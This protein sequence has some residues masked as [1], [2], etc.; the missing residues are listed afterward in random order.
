MWIWH[1]SKGEMR[2]V[3]GTLFSSGYSGHGVGKNE[4]SAQQVPNTGPIPV[5][6]YQIGLPFDDPHKG[7]C[8][9]SLTPHPANL[10][11]GRSGFLIHGDNATHDAS[12]GCIILPPWA[13]Q[14][15]ARSGDKLLVV[16]P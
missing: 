6:A 4:P 15:L 9:M 12:E 14:S 3:D 8:V 16:L 2:G 1:Q 13:R 7:P 11:F 10:M 5:G